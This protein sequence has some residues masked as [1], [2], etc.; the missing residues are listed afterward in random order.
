MLSLV[1]ELRFSLIKQKHQEGRSHILIVSTNPGSTLLRVW[2]AVG[3]QGILAK[4][5]PLYMAL[6]SVVVFIG[7]GCLRSKTQ[8][9]T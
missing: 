9:E 7:L 3:A 1:K 4:P 5:Y 2:H 8:E 6:T